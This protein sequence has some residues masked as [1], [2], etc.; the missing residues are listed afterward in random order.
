MKI[1]RRQNYDLSK[2]TSAI[3]N[4][5]LTNII[6]RRRSC[7]TYV[8]RE[9]EREMSFFL[10]LEVQ[11][12]MVFGRRVIK[13]REVQP[14]NVFD[15]LIKHGKVFRRTINGNVQINKRKLEKEESLCYINSRSRYINTQVYL[16]SV[17]SKR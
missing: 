10:L 14:Q 17:I 4:E 12:Q 5:L 3:A 8:L 1:V 7:L 13:P 2:N 16:I 15:T 9:R 6:S 11:I